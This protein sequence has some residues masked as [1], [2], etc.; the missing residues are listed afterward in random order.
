MCG[1]TE[2]Y[3]LDSPVLCYSHLAFGF[4]VR[5]TGFGRVR[6][7]DT[8]CAKEIY[9]SLINDE[10]TYKV[11]TKFKPNDLVWVMHNNSP[12]QVKVRGVVFERAMMND[13]HELEGGGHR[14]VFYGDYADSYDF[15][16]FATKR[17][18]MEYVFDLGKEDE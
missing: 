5:K 13:E 17:E 2:V 3:L 18:L 8:K 7:I 11:D 6:F 10:M 1:E 9:K 14:Y 15:N 4:V 12:I 16:T